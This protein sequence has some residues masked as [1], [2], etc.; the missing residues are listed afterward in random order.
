MSQAKEEIKQTKKHSKYFLYFTGYTG[1][2]HTCTDVN[3]CLQNNGGCSL[4][5]LV[6]CINTI[7][8]RNCGACP[9]GKMENISILC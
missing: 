4:A 5:P 2:G 1:N 6:A 9:A 3:E 8:S 7:G